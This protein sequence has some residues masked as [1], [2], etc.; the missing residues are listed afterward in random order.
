MCQA[1]L[2]IVKD[3]EILR[4]RP[5]TPRDHVFSEQDMYPHQSTE[6]QVKFSVQRCR[7]ESKESG[8]IYRQEESVT[9]RV[10]CEW[11]LKDE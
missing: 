11:F 1:L 4:Q 10:P 7:R 9:E 6:W 5:C 2:L 3:E 8:S